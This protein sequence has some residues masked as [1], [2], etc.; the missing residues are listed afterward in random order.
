M[1]SIE[2]LN[3]IFERANEN[4]ADF[5]L[6]LG[7]L[8]NDY[9]GS[10]E[11]LNAYLN[12]S[13]GFDVYGVYGN[14]ELE[15]ENNS[16]QAVTP[17][18]TNRSSEV[19]WGT[20][21]GKIG[22]GSVGYYY[23]DRED[24]RVVCTDTQYSYM[25]DIAEW[26]HNP[27]NS[28]GEPGILGS[29]LGPEQLLWLEEVLTDAADKG[30]KCIVLSHTAF[31]GDWAGASSDA[32]AVAAIFA[33][34]NAIRD[35]TVMMAI[36]GHYHTNRIQSKDNICYFDVNTVRNG[37]W[38]KDGTPHY[39][40]TQTFHYVS[41]DEEGSPDDSGERALNTLWQ[42]SNTWFFKDPLSAIVTIS[43][44]TGEIEIKGM[45]TSWIYDVAPDVNNEGTMPE[46]YNSRIQKGGEKL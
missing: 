30:R 23:F 28:W 10:P 39:T 33:K 20:A 44:D 2:D 5:V 27:T 6:H 32:D 24:L 36:N 8:S 38:M 16:M 26:V 31:N 25:E 14:H 21:N 46:I 40:E 34:V 1:S 43:L 35:G 37:Y 18:L 12:N 42:A 29:S 19:V 41:Y 17:K 3:R 45:K 7:D 22:D 9:V 4:K 15:S 11:L 13:H